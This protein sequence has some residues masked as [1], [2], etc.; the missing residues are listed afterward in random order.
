[1]IKITDKPISPE[2]VV[3]AIK[4][5][6]SG[7]VVTYVGLIRDNSRGKPVLSVEYED[8]R[9][10]AEDGLRQIA[11]EIKNPKFNVPVGMLLA[12]VVVLGLYVAVTF[13]TVG[14]LDHSILQKSLTPISDGGRTFWGIPGVIITAIAALLA[15]VSTANAGIMSASRYPLAMGRDHILPKIFLKINKRFKTPHFL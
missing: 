15:F 8:T 12:Y 4:T 9:G 7:C 6:D 2:L 11:E 5:P 3:N 10:T 14:V 1:M 13:I